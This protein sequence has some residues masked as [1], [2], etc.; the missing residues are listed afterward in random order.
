[1]PSP[2]AQRPP[3]LQRW[4][5]R[6][7]PG[8]LPLDA[9][10]AEFRRVGKHFVARDLLEA[11]AQARAA[12][13]PGD[14]P[15]RR[16]L[17]T[18]LDKYDDR[19]DNPTYLAIHDL[20]LP[21]MAGHG[22]VGF[23]IR[24]A[25]VQ[26][27]LLIML[28][29]ADLLRFE[30][31]ALD[32]TTDLLPLMRPQR[33]TVA[34]RCTLGMRALRPAMMRLGLEATDDLGDPIATV[35]V[36]CDRVAAEQTDEE[37]R[38]LAVTLLTVYTAHDE[39]LFV[40]VLQCYETTFALIAVQLQAAIIAAATCDGARAARALRAAEQAM[41]EARPLFS[42][43]AT[44]EPE[45]F[46][47]F[48]EYTDGASAIQSRS[49]KTVESLCRT[50]DDDRLA[51]PGFD[52]APEVRE[53]VL[54]GQ[55][56]VQDAVARCPDPAGEIRAAMAALQASVLAW[57]RTHFNLAMR[58]LG[59]KRGTGYTAGVPYLAEHKDTPLFGGAAQLVVHRAA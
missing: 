14:R 55:P 37:R 6:P 24:R 49:Y 48:R 19:F 16:F 25:A 7:D 23:D 5:R 47:T 20:P 3:E 29:V 43:V 2:T 45:A 22:S 15:L 33:R 51:G 59:L 39:N 9:V 58:V 53:R 46:L 41:R 44:M 1:M 8:T 27:D 28:L 57:R 35:R 13:P 32:G 18:A 42:L 4:L 31:A 21:A 50:P 30:L 11:L 26:R 34:K 38:M 56:T 17:D 36:L 12:L 52:A 10:I 40:R 54:A